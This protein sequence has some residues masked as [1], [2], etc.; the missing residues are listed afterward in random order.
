MNL[1]WNKEEFETYVLLFAAHCNQLETEE[2]VAYILSKVGEMIYN[3]M[4]TEIVVSKEEE[5]KRKIKDYLFVNQYSKEEKENLLKEVKEVFFA[6][7]T[8]DS[9]EKKTF[10]FFRK[11]LN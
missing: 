5:S 11:I 3:K 2:E 6:D 9:S 10:T 1:Y 4:H 7:G 8:V